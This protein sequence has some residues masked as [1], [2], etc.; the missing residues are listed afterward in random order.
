MTDEEIAQGKAAVDAM[1][2]AKSNMQQVLD[3]NAALVADLEKWLSLA[4]DLRKYVPDMFE[5][6]TSDMT[7]AAKLLT[8]IHATKALL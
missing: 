1:K 7:P 3:R 2:N 6:K 4:S 5:H 8:R